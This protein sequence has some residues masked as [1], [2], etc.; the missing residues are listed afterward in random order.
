MVRNRYEIKRDLVVK[1]LEKDKLIGYIDNLIKNIYECYISNDLEKAKS[2]I[3]YL[4]EII[5]FSGLKYP[6]IENYVNYR[7]VIISNKILESLFKRDS[8]LYYPSLKL[9]LDDKPD[10][11]LSELLS[12]DDMRMFL[13]YGL[14]FEEDFNRFLDFLMNL[15]EI[16]YYFNGKLTM[17]SRIPRQ[18]IA[19]IT[20]FMNDVKK[21]VYDGYLEIPED[22]IIEDDDYLD[23]YEYCEKRHKE[24]K[25]NASDG[26]F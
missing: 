1:N 9:N 8:Q 18:C 16:K 3:E 2:N 11:Y 17:N 10:D 6:N 12:D 20:D 23:K 26:V 24:R 21:G 15:P 25:N 13:D 22:Y 4:H 19:K 14:E 7:C 5:S